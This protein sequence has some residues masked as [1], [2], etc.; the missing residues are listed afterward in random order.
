MTDVES[1]RDW[2]KDLSPRAFGFPKHWLGPLGSLVLIDGVGVGLEMRPM[3]VKG[4]LG[5]ELV[6]VK[7]KGEWGNS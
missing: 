3:G 6:R 1:R 2:W 7:E 5:D 4:R